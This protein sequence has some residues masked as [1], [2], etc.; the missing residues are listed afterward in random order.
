MAGAADL[1]AERELVACLLADGTS[2]AEATMLP[3]DAITTPALALVAAEAMRQFGQG[4]IPDA[5]TVV[6]A[7][8]R[9]GQLKAAGGTSAVL[10]LQDEVVTTLP[11][12]VRHLSE[13]LHAKW[14]LRLLTR[15][16]H[17]FMR[18]A[19][20]L[21]GGIA[22]RPAADV[23]AEAVTVL[24]QARAAMEDGRSL[25]L[26]GHILRDLLADVEVRQE[27]QVDDLAVM[28]GIRSVD[29]ILAGVA[30]GQLVTVAARPGMG[31]T[32]F[33]L[34]WLVE[35]AKR[36]VPGYY[37]SLEMTRH[38]IAVR[39]ASQFSGLPTDRL[40]G[41]EPLTAED[42]RDLSH[43]MGRA[44]ELPIAVS[45]SEAGV[46]QLRADIHRAR[47][48]LGAL[49]LV[50]VDQLEMI[51]MAADRQKGAREDVAW[52][53]TVDRLK[54]LA[55]AENVGIVL[56]HQLRREAEERPKHIPQLRDL[57]ETS[58]VE[59]RSDKIVF[60]VQPS[61]YADTARLSPTDPDYNDHRL[62][63]YVAKHRMGK[64]GAANVFVDLERSRITA[65]DSV[66]TDGGARR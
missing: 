45:D 29:K 18:L 39:I 42:W 30:P 63:I 26:V 57:A 54:R 58:V 4:D 48:A 21:R 25:F 11:G 47:N 7:L 19:G 38:E 56:L 59:R 22:D 3:P 53:R 64:T 23:L 10:R 41:C 37:A 49:R 50:V 12:Y 34:W 44:A 6:Q 36:G 51:D 33:G 16:A 14:A 8:D 1:E 52:G 13:R 31:K 20:D 2:C 66:H 43:G 40:T 62:D 9:A 24:D 60:L 5:V 27:P 17:D 61:Q 46:G 35:A 55:K 28:T 15:Y 32:L 65:V